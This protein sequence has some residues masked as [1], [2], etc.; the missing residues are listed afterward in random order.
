M[1]GNGFTVTVEFA[2]LEQP[3]VVTVTVY[4]VV[5]VG[6]AVTLAPVVEDKPPA[7]DHVYVPPPVAFKAVLEPEQ[8]AGELTV[9]T[10]RGFTVTV[11]VAVP[12]QLPFEPVTV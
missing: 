7:G 6:F 9:T 3:D 12:E 5:L 2:E 11:E 4:V 8:I 1:T 10:G